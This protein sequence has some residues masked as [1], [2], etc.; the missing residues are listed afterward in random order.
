MHAVA[1]AQ[2]NIQRL[3]I[4]IRRLI[5]AI[6]LNFWFAGG[7]LFQG[8]RVRQEVI[9]RSLVKRMTGGWNV[10]FVVLLGGMLC[11]FRGLG[12][13]HPL[14]LV[15]WLLPF[16]GIYFHLALAPIPWQWA[17]DGPRRVATIRGLIVSLAFNATWIGG[18]LLLAQIFHPAPPPPAPPGWPPNAPF[19]PMG[20]GLANPIF[21]VG[22]INFAFATF[23]GWGL[24]EKEAMEAREQET[25]GLLRQ[26]ES[27]ALQ[28]Q[29][30]PHVLYNALSSLS[31]LIYE[32]PLAAETVITRLADLY[33]ILSVH[34]KRDRVLLR[35]ERK[36]VEAYL[37]MEQMRLGERLKVSWDWPIDVDDLS[38]PP[39]FLQP[40]VENAIKHGIGPSEAG[41]EIRISCHR[42][43]GQI[44]LMVQ[45]TGIPPPEKLSHG[46][47]IGNLVARLA[48]WSEAKGT[49][50]MVREGM[51]TQ[52]IL[53]WKPGGGA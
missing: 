39:L 51:W 29:L 12:I 10:V 35:E 41:G 50:T 23:V 30:E 27:K 26:A 17:Q 8:V 42:N 34:G 38:L 45:N 14:S 46:I 52:A 16:V 3:Q 36:L 5:H 9:L 2:I 25:A 20:P 33:R 32:D 22:L 37:S 28:N 48:L 47:G 15:E 6:R 11:L 40:L 21:G 13:R 19:P 18:L 31:E 53:R 44:S 1:L 7:D 43:E 4:D 24:A 49:F